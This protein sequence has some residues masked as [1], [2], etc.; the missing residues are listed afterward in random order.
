MK[1]S[2]ARTTKEPRQPAGLP[3]GPA[4]L[5]D[6]TATISP[7]ARIYPSVRGTT[8]TIGA[9]T[10]VHEFVVIK[11]IGGMGDVTIG[12]HCQLNSGTVL[13]SGCGISIGNDVLIAPSCVIAPAN[14]EFRDPRVPIRLQRFMSSRGGV[15]IE[16]DVWIGANCTLLDGTHI[17]KGSII[18]AGSVVNGKVDGYCIYAGTPARKVRERK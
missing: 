18:A 6:P 11:A 16:D 4:L 3:Q 2:P 7:D 13:Y 9:H 1:E 17:G 5:V 14:H 12:S 8:I 15:V 10:V